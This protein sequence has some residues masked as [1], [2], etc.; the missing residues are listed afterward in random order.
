MERWG[1]GTVGDGTVGER[2]GK[3]EVFVINFKGFVLESWHLGGGF[4]E[5]QDDD[6]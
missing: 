2:R 6:W 5:K 4:A 3:A 1:D